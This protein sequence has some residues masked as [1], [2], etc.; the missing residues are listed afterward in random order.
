MNSV[1]MMLLVPCRIKP[2]TGD[3]SLLF[4]LL[5]PGTEGDAEKE[6]TP[7]RLELHQLV[8]NYENHW[9]TFKEG[10]EITLIAG[11]DKTDTYCVAIREAQPDGSLGSPKGLVV[12][13]M[14]WTNMV[15]ACKGE[16]QE[17]IR[18]RREAAA[19]K[20]A[21][22]TAKTT[23]KPAQQGKATVVTVNLGSAPKTA[24]VE[25]SQEETEV[26]APTGEVE[27]VSVQGSELTVDQEKAIEAA[28]PAESE[29]APVQEAEQPAKGKGKGKSSR[30]GD[31][32][33]SKVDD[34]LG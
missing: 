7:A 23:T 16:E 25:E 18:K 6:A 29:P 10:S 21:Q 12:R 22:Q 28:A 30:R 9:Y 19:L 5:V 33:A 3:V 4:P 1:T 24:P 17:I 26:Q 34:I 32:D 27:V 8:N 15:N 13:A 20:V 31:D 14:A 11:V 2:S